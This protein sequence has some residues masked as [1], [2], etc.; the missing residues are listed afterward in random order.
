M[1]IQTSKVEFVSKTAPETRLQSPRLMSSARI[2]SPLNLSKPMQMEIV[3]SSY[4]IQQMK[5]KQYLMNRAKEDV[6]NAA[7]N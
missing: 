4:E 2:T 5:Y 6:E 1:A 3:P 7:K